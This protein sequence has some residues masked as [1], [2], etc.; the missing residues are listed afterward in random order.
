MSG[1]WVVVRTKPREEHIAVV[2]INRQH[3]DT[4]LPRFLDAFK[5]PRLL[6]PS[7][8][9]VFSDAL[10]LS[11]L[12]NTSGVSN[13]LRMGQDIALCPDRIITR[14][15]EMEKE[16]FVQ[17]APAFTP[18]QPVV[19]NSGPLHDVTGL[20]EGQSTQGRV[21]VLLNLLGRQTR[22]CLMSSMVDAA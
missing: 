15:R 20:Y 4:Y 8:L 11:W 10:S 21:N 12:D 14:L 17:L 18:G 7:Y 16:G 13:I 6:F 22:V 2:H 19:I 1:R 9:F 3:A 5:N